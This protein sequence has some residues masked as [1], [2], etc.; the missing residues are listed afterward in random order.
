MPR[1][2]PL[3]RNNKRR[4]RHVAS[5]DKRLSP[6]KRGYGHAWRKVRAAFLVA[7]PL[8]Q[9]CLA[10]NRTTLATEVHHITK[11]RNDPALLYDFANLMALCKRCHARRTA[12]GE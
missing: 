4:Q 9:D 12:R 1:R 11:H 3:F 5:T 8:C 6:S 2:A 7:H 10:D